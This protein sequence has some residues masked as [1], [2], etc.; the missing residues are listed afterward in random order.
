MAIAVKYAFIG[1]GAAG[2]FGALRAAAL[3]A[4]GTKVLILEKSQTLLG[5]VR[6]S[7]GGRCNVTHACFDPQELTAFYPRGGRE[8]LGAFHRF[9]TSDTIAWFEERGVPLNTEA[10]G[11]MFPQSNTSQTIVDCFLQ[12][13]RKLNVEIKTGCGVQSL[14]PFEG[15]WQL[16]TTAGPVTA[17][18]VLIASGSS[19]QVW[20][21]L[22]ALGHTLAPPVPSL[23]TFNLKDPRLTGLQ[24]LSVPQARAAV[25]GTS[26]AEEGPLLVTHWGL[27]GPC[28]LRLSAWGARALHEKNYR[29]DLRINWVDRDPAEVLETLRNLRDSEGRKLIGATPFF[30]LPAR[31]WKSFCAHCGITDLKWASASNRQLEA[32]CTELSNGAYAVNGKSTFKEE[33]VTC[34]GIKLAEIYPTSFESRLHPGLY[35]AGEALDIDAITGGFNFQAAWTTSW[36]ASSDMC[37]QSA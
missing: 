27:S 16:Q 11:R 6:V 32:L 14:V 20:D 2:F 21:M 29:F 13:A 17:E 12:E 30:G 5:K 37:G 1:G 18:K 3:S 23:F 9:M 34:G 7:G 26:L 24:G 22:S 33:F 15:G 8:L 36:I 31:L 28:I 10:D 19:G 4:P 25:P 35:F